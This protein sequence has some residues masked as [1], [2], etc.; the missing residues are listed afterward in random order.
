MRGGRSSGLAGAAA[1]ANEDAT[2]FK[3]PD[4]RTQYIER[5]RSDYMAYRAHAAPP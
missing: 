4:N 5:L 3:A 1:L 2:I